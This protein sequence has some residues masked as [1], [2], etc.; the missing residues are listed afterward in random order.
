MTLTQFLSTLTTD[1]LS[2]TIKESGE[3][4]ATLITFTS[5]GYASIE[6]DLLAKSVVSWAVTKTNGITVIISAS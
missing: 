1:N 2:V 6:S 5:G 3:S 4:G